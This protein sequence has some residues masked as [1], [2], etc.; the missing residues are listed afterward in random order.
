[1]AAATLSTSMLSVLQVD[2]DED[3]LGADEERGV[4]AGDE[5]ERRGDDFIARADARREHRAVQ[6]GGSGGDADARA[7]ARLTLATAASNSSSRGPMVSCR[8]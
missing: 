4:G 7:V 6:P 1:M 3:R 8:L 5:G 2:V